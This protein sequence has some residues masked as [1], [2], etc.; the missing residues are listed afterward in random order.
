MT[1]FAEF[2]RAGW[3]GKA[4]GYDRLLGRVTARVVGDL[5]DAAHVGAGTR[6]LDVGCGAGDAC[7]AAAARGALPT[8]VDLAPAMIALARERHPGLD[9]RVGSAE[10]LPAGG[11]DAVIG[12]FLVHH[13]AEPERVVRG[14]AEV[15]APGGRLALTSWDQP[16]RC[17]LVGVLLDAIA[18]VGAQPPPDLPPAPPFFRFAD[19]GEFAALLT[20]A[21]FTGVSVTTVAFTHGISGADELWAT[22]IE[23]TVRTA[24]LVQGQRDRVRAAIRTEF[25]RRV[26]EHGQEIPVSVTLAA[27]AT[28]RTGNPPR[29]A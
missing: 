4:A 20:G 1:G 3:A 10:A 14:F 7:A 8:G 29:S 21:G 16:A 26:A 19:A 15:L 9:L 24:A 12:N 13:L 18:A 25:D 28:A 6:V 22:L 5:L 2:E 27:G 11:V 17:R 23:G